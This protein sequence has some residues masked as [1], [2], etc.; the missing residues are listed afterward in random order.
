MS[1]RR[2]DNELVRRGLAASRT[3]AQAAIREGKVVVAGSPAAKASTLVDPAAPVE[4]VGAARRF[5]SRGGEKLD[6]ALERFGV[7]AA[8]RRALDAGAST[9]GFTDC[10]LQRGAA[11]V[12]ALDVGYG[13]LAW[14]IRTDERVT[15][16]ERTNVREL[17]A[18]HLPY[19]P[20][21][22]AA[23]LSF[24]SLTLAVPPLAAVAAPG[25]DLLLLVKPQFEAGP[26]DVGSRGVVRDPGVW[27][28]A[29]EAV[30]AACGA[31]ELAPTAVMA[32]PL[33][34]PAG[35]VEFPMHVRK[36]PGPVVLDLDDAVLEGLRVAGTA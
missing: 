19:A 27:R 6:A 36:G 33:P 28:R 9:G 17:T 21:L 14:A 25:A 16:L 29:L 4:L 1:R 10:L 35:N 11:H 13:Q 15:V 32:S 34:G 22:V 31:A 20:D 5:V 8:G 18:A 12:V 3:E 26:S 7:D 30:A 2:L 24:I 23:D